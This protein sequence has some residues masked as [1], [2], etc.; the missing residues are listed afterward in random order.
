MWSH[1]AFSSRLHAC[2]WDCVW[3]TVCVCVCVCVC[4]DPPPVASTLYIRLNG[5]SVHKCVC[6]HVCVWLRH[7]TLWPVVEWAPQKLPLSPLHP[8]TPPPRPPPNPTTLS[9]GRG[10]CYHPKRGR[11]AHTH[12][13]THTHKLSLCAS[14]RGWWRRK[15]S[16]LDSAAFV[17]PWWSL[18]STCIWGRKSPLFPL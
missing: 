8:S 13:H 14:G 16:C 6:V 7:L 10:V 2:V 3:E 1:S 12:T 18:S 9:H 15:A 17:P 4:E 11:Q 5:S